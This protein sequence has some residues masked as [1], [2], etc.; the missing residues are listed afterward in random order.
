MDGAY[1]IEI[2]I[3]GL[4]SFISW[5][6]RVLWIKVDSI[7]NESNDANQSILKLEIKMAETYLGKKEFESSFNKITLR[8]EKIDDKIDQI[9]LYNNKCNK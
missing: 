9:I 8:L 7:L 2:A 1:Y 3:A 4:V 6:L 5:Y